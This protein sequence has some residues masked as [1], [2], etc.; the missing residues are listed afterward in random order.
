MT[1][2]AY[3]TFYVSPTSPTSLAIAHKPTNSPLHLPY[4]PA[5]NLSTI[6]IISIHIISSSD[7]RQQ[8]PPSMADLP[9]GPTNPLT[10]RQGSWMGGQSNCPLSLSS[11]K[12]SS[13]H[14]VKLEVSV[15]VLRYAS[16]SA[17][18]SGSRSEVEVVCP[19]IFCCLCRTSVE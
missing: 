6:Y 15:T 4:Y 2:I 11:G 1:R 8:S 7:I 14:R 9:P 3:F 16:A 18:Y 12:S 10:A 17:N 13:K 5:P 19:K